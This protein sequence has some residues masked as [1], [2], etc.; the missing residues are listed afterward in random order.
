MFVHM[1][2]ARKILL[3]GNPKGYTIPAIA[4]ELPG[5]GKIFVCAEVPCFGVNSQEELDYSSD[6]KKIS[7]QA[8]PVA[9]TL[10]VKSAGKGVWEF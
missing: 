9:E 1:I 2:K 3:I 4:K 8:G 5:D 7:M 6:G 10:K